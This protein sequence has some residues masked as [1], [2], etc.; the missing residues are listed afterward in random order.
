MSWRYIWSKT[1]SK[2]QKNGVTY[3]LKYCTQSSYVGTGTLVQLEQNLSIF[4][5][6]WYMIKNGVLE[7]RNDV[8]D[9]NVVLK[10]VMWDVG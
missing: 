3:W 4:N 6:V 10:L 5:Q 7:T 9:L 1:L 8:I 2:K